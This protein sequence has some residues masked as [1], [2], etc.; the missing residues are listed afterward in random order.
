MRTFVGVRPNPPAEYIEK[1]ITNAGDAPDYEGVVFSDGT[2]AI[3]WL[4]E[5][6]S[7]SVWKSYED[8]FQVHGHMEYG[9][10]IV[11]DD[12][13]KPPV[14]D[15]EYEGGTATAVSSGVPFTHGVRNTVDGS[16]GGNVIQ[17]HTFNKGV[18]L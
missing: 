16:V 2:V 17:G 11:F 3:R 12:G 5:Y 7:T 1:G 14:Y 8:F 10:K 9:T 4:T 18:N 13:G 6:Q 15:Y